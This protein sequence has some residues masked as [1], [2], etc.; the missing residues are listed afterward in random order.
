L[1]C[2]ECRAD[3][4]PTP[5]AATPTADTPTSQGKKKRNKR[6]N[7]KNQNAP[8]TPEAKANGEA[9]KATTPANTPA[10]T[11]PA[12]MPAGKETTPKKGASAVKKFPNGLEVETLAIGKPDGKKAAAGKK[13]GGKK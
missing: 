6:K 1:L 10:A 9:G 2:H 12:A 13:V 5:G 4:V 3:G 7:K 8:E 11:T